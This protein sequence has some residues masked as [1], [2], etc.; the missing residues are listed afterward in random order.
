MDGLPVRQIA[1]R[2]VAVLSEVKPTL[3][4]DGV[5]VK[6]QFSEISPIFIGFSDGGAGFIN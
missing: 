6:P 4:R 3:G 5:A 2:R 1:F